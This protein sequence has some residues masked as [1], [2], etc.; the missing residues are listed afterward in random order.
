[1]IGA[2]TNRYADFLDV[3]C[4][5]TGRAPAFGLHLDGPRRGQV[6]VR[7][8]GVPAALRAHPSLYPVLGYH[9]GGILGDRV[10]VLADLPRT[11]RATSRRSA[12]PRRARAPSP[13]PMS[14]AS[15]PKPRPSRRP[16][17]GGRLKRRS[18]SP[19]TTSGGRGHAC[20]S[21]RRPVSTS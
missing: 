15:R 3:A 10:P 19:W 1:V 9:L 7:L 6:L 13:W 2:R 4:A 11:L 16:S 14:S 21:P 8:D 12:R 18:A 20:R 17:K 5:V